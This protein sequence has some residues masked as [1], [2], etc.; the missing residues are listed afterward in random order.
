MRFDRIV[1]D[2]RRFPVFSSANGLRIRFVCLSIRE[3]LRAV[4]K[5]LNTRK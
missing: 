5:D 4:A 2:T 1:Y 3:Y